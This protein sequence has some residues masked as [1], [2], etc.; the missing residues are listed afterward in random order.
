METHTRPTYF[1]TL[2]VAL[3]SAGYDPNDIDQILWESKT[4]KY[5]RVRMKPNNLLVF[6]EITTHS[7]VIEH[8]AHHV[9]HAPI[10]KAT[11]KDTDPLKTL[12]KGNPA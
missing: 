6:V 11:T 4:P 7:L 8:K 2:D 9:H 12:N 3:I 5:L 1:S 10:S